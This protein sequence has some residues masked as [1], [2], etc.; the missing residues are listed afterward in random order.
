MTLPDDAVSYFW[1][2]VERG[3][4]NQCW[5]W[6]RCLGDKSYGSCR[7]AYKKYIQATHISLMIDGRPRPDKDHQALHSC[8]NPP[9]VNPNHL[10]WGTRE[11][12]IEDRRTRGRF[13]VGPRR[14]AH[15]V[16]AQQWRKFVEEARIRDRCYARARRAVERGE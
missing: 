6:K 11:E 5:R 14:T 10:R 8:D 13:R 16:A 7:V 1:E 2:N 4:Q 3:D 12:N 15:D 9:C